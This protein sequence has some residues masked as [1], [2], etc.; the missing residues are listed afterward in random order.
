MRLVLTLCVMCAALIATP[1]VHAAGTPPAE[2]IAKLR[3]YK[4]EKDDWLPLL[5][6]VVPQLSPLYL[7]LPPGA[8]IDRGGPIE[9]ALAA[10]DK[11]DGPSAMPVV[12]YK[13]E[14]GRLP[15][16]FIVSRYRGA[17]PAQIAPRL[18]PRDAALRHHLVDQCLDVTPLESVPAGE[19]GEG[20]QVQKKSAM[21]ALKMPLGAGWFGLRSSYAFGDW[22]SVTLPNGV[23]LMRFVNRPARPDERVKFAAFKDKKDQQLALDDTH[24]EAREYRLSHLFLP[25]RDPSGGM[26]TIHVYFVRIVPSLKP[27]TDLVGSGALAR[28]VFA[29][30]AHDALVTP[31]RIIREEVE[32]VRAGK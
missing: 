16:A 11:L 31:V 14:D 32:R 8:T 6:S 15:G 3:E 22:E 2:A 7:A 17:T 9:A 23:V 28:W 27:G 26:N 1:A 24:F 30:G 29:K 18:I 21:F 19:Y 12:V 20:A 25:E 13:K 10:R 4:A 5:S